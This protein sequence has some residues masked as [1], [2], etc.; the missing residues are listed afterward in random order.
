MVASVPREGIH[1]KP[2]MKLARM[3]P[4]VLT[5]EAIP[6]PCPTALARRV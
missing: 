6:M 1:Q 4:A 5:A 3:L 2:T